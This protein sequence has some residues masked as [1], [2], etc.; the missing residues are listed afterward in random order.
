MHNSQF[1]IKITISPIF[2]NSLIANILLR[3][4][5]GICQSTP[6][7]FLCLTL[8]QNLK[9]FLILTSIFLVKSESP[10]LLL[11]FPFPLTSTVLN[12]VYKSMSIHSDTI[13][14]FRELDIWFRNSTSEFGGN[15][16]IFYYKTNRY[17][18]IIQQFHN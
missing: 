12:I 16:M 18:K 3:G 6:I 1:A 13:S 15:F 7:I 9:A 14:C 17:L 2:V 11:Y 10:F 5:S 4:D 8:N